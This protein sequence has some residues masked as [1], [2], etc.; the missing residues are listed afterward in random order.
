M[1]ADLF[2]YFGHDRDSAIVDLEQKRSNYDNDYYEELW[3]RKGDLKTMA[4]VFSWYCDPEFN[5]LKN[6]IFWFI[7]SF[8]EWLDI[9]LLREQSILSERIWSFL[10]E[11]SGGIYMVC[12]WWLDN[13]T[14]TPKQIELFSR[15]AWF[16][17]N[18]E[19]L[20][21]LIKAKIEMKRIAGHN[22]F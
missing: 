1:S 20:N 17:E 18:I 16:S 4:E 12:W 10:S 22:A 8:L 7:A 21:E 19:E 6:E 3:L 2:P 15:V 5:N 9:H 14:L 13:A 11:Y